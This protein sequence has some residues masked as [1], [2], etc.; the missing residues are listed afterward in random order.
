VAVI[1]LRG[2]HLLR[3][4]PR[5]GERYAVIGDRRVESLCSHD[6]FSFPHRLRRQ[7]GRF[8]YRREAAHAGGVLAARSHGA[9]SANVEMVRQR[10]SFSPPAR[11]RIAAAP[12]HPDCF[13]IRPLPAQRGSIVISAKVGH[14]RAVIPQRA[15][16]MAAR[17]RPTSAKLMGGHDTF[18]AFQRPPQ[19]GQS[20]IQ[21]QTFC[22]RWKS[23]AKRQG[24]FDPTESPQLDAIANIE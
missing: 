8:A 17:G 21:V 1:D 3:R 22:R 6:G 20:A 11:L 9:R 2:E 24:W 12:P 15:G 13:A 16:E 4:P 10:A 18:M 19:R 5:P 7:Y 23:L 14:V